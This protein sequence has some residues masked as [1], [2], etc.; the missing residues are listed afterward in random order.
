MNQ[1]N[2]D[3]DNK[4]TD[5]KTTKLDSLKKKK[6]Q[7]ENQ[8][9]LMEAKQK[10]KLRKEETRKKILVGSYHLDQ[11]REQGTMENINQIMEQY[12]NRNIDRKLF[13]LPPLEQKPEQP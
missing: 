5:K 13:G 3:S 6:Q 4:R 10:T 7:I 11:A 9:K 12:L 1:S 8:I 2:A